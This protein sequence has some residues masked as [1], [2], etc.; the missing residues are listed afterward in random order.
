ME[1]YMSSGRFPAMSGSKTAYVETQVSTRHP[2][3]ILQVFTVFGT[4]A[5]MYRN[6]KKFFGTVS[7]ALGR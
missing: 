1:E 7:A 2:W 4:A 5:L 6:V 3:E